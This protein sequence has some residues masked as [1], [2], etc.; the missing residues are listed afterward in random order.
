MRQVR[1]NDSSYTLYSQ[2]YGETYHSTSGALDEALR[3]FIEPC[4]IKDGMN[5]L[6]IGFG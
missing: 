2:M 3:K 1:T 4:G 6:D 5:I